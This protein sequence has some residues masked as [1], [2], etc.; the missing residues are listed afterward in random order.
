MSRICIIY[1]DNDNVSAASNSQLFSAFEQNFLGVPMVAWSVMQAK[2]AGI[3]DRIVV[4]TPACCAGSISADQLKSFGASD[5]ISD[6]GNGH[7]INPHDRIVQVVHALQLTGCNTI[8]ALDAASPV[9]LP[10]DIAHAVNL[11]EKNRAASVVSARNLSDS[12]HDVSV[13]VIGL[14]QGRAVKLF[15]AA[16]KLN[17]GHEHSASEAHYMLTP[18]IAVWPA[19]EF[20]ANPRT[21]VRDGGGDCEPSQIYPMPSQRS[22]HIDSDRAMLHARIDMAALLLGNGKNDRNLNEQITDGFVSQNLPPPTLRVAM[23]EAGNPERLLSSS[24]RSL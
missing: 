20:L 5:V 13:S 15:G 1:Q 23:R 18:S 8:V 24:T 17:P 2:A 16:K 6:A 7:E 10:S 11:Q 14:Q 4:V 21:F 9:R 3:F 19:T 22:K 12:V